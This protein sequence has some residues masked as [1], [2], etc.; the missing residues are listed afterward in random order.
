M[1]WNLVDKAVGLRLHVYPG[2]NKQNF[3][4]HIALVCSE[5]KDGI[6]RNRVWEQEGV[7]KW[8]IPTSPHHNEEVKGGNPN[9]SGLPKVHF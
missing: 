4:I 1:C 8:F 3:I 5:T 9:D 7:L 6:I 2:E